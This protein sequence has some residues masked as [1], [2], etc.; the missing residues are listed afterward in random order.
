MRFVK[1]VTTKPVVGVGRFTSPDAMVSQIRRGILDFIG[2]ARPSI[3]DPFLPRKIENGDIDDIRECIGCNVCVTRR[4][5]HDAHTLHAKSDHGRGMAQGL[6]PRTRRRP[7]PATMTFLI[8]GAGP[9][10]PR[11]RAAARDGAAIR[12]ISP[13][14]ADAARRTGDARIAALP[15]LAAWARVRDYRTAAAEENAERRDSA[16]QP[17]HA[18]SRSWNSAPSAWCSPPAPAGA[19]TAW[20]A[21]THGP[22]PGF[23]IARTVS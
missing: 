3:A 13:R 9:C 20:A 6:A 17:R 5:H 10:G 7:A 21:R 16:R 2:A 4:P 15:G 1:T 8:V 14:R 12:C 19:A 11:M 22:I 23:D 18:R